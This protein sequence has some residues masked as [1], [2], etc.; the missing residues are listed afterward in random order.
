MFNLKKSLIALIAVFTLCG[1]EGRAE[2]FT[3]TNVQGVLWVWTSMDG[4]PPILR[5][6]P[7]FH[8]SGPGLS[9]SRFSGLSEY[10]DPGNVEAREA[11]FP[12]PCSPGMV[13][14]TNSNFSGLL[15]RNTVAVVN[16]VQVFPVTLTGSLNFVSSPIVLPNFGN[17]SRQ[18]TIPFAFS[19]DITGVGPSFI[20]PPFSATLSG[21]GFATFHFDPLIG[22][23]PLNPR[24]R[25]Y[26]IEYQFEPARMLV[27]IKPASLPNMINPRSRGKIPVAIL[28]TELFDATAVDPTTVLFGATGMEVAPVQSATEDVDGDGDLD[29]V[30]HFVTQD[31]GITCGNTFALLTAVTFG[32]ETVKGFDSIETVGCN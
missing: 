29:M 17:A 11:C 18:I 12:I 13:L 16:G 22:S 19:G 8:L 26:G 6:P 20:A 5:L 7:E 14:G 15:G 28:T 3:I 21:Y 30:L 10:G 4:G 2:S 9:V 1:V 25:L 23:D 24:Y 32:G 27:D 31:T